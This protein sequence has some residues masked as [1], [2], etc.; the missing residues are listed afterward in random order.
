M[1]GWSAKMA[2]GNFYLSLGPSH[3]VNLPEM[4]IVV[5]SFL[6]QYIVQM[7]NFTSL[8]AFLIQHSTGIS[9]QNCWYG[10]CCPQ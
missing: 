8:K 1:P 3:W 7:C 10:Y 4:I 5:M 6:Q 2:F 9:S